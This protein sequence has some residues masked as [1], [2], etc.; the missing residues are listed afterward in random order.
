MA[1]YIVDEFKVRRS[2][3]AAR[4]RGIRIYVSD[5]GVVRTE[6][7]TSESINLDRISDYAKNDRRY[8]NEAPLNLITQF[9][10]LDTFTRYTVRAIDERPFVRV[11]DELNSTDCGYETPLPQPHVPFNPFGNPTYKSYR[12]YNYCNYEDLPSQILIEKKDYTGE[13]IAINIAGEYPVKYNYQEVDNKFE[14]IRPLEIELTFI[15]SNNFELEEFYTEDERTFRVTITEGGKLK[16]KGYIIPDSCKEGFE[17]GN[18][19]VSVKCTDA[20][21][22][23]KT[24]TFP[25][26]RGS[27]FDL[28][29]SF[30]GVLCYC[31]SPTNLNLNI[32]TI[33]N[34]YATGMPTGLG[35]DPLDMATI[36][37]LRLA[38]DKGATL[39]CFDVLNEVCK[40]WGMYVVQQNAEWNFVRF[41]EQAQEVVRQ[42]SYNYTGFRI[43]QQQ[44][45]NKRIIGGVF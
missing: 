7:T 20:I 33:C 16:A 44:V 17:A 45:A 37:P 27:T 36:N 15:E 2:G 26:D 24:V 38:D 23:L 12:T 41:N 9:C 35:D 29:Q 28:Q 21:Q 25:I 10:N 40:A 4:W 13:N 3:F 14:T 6:D 8:P 43:S 32:N 42:R 31:L 1:E 39:T 34:F 11:T 30:V 19:I 18:N 22:S 5:G